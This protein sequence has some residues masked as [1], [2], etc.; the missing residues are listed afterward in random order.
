M[1]VNMV[2]ITITTLPDHHPDRNTQK[3]KTHVVDNH[4]NPG[5]PVAARLFRTQYKSKLSANRRLDS[6]SNRH[7]RH[8]C[9][10]AASWGDVN[11]LHF[12]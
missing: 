10:I 8:P 1:W 6:Y 2:E 12:D 9:H 3:E 7:R 4:R 11:I 5:N